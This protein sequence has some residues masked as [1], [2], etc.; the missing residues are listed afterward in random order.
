MTVPFVSGTAQPFLSGLS[1]FSVL[2]QVNANA[3]AV[4]HACFS[5]HSWIPLFS[6]PLS[7]TSKTAVG[8]TGRDVLDVLNEFAGNIDD[9][10]A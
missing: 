2:A 5:S 8:D 3:I 9:V 1:Q 7:M 6:A 10:D 4:V